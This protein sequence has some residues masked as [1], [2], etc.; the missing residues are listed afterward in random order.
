[1]KR[2]NFSS[3]NIAPTA[4]NVSLLTAIT[5]KRCVLG[6]TFG[7][8]NA[9]IWV[10]GCRGTFECNGQTVKC[11]HDINVHAKANLRKVRR[12]ACIA[13]LEP[14]QE[15][16]SPCVAAAAEQCKPE[17]RTAP[18]RWAW[19][20]CH[21]RTADEGALGLA[22]TVVVAVRYSE[23]L[24]TLC[25]LASLPLPRIYVVNK[26]APWGRH[27]ISKLGPGFVELSAPN[28]GRESFSYLHALLILR[29]Y[30]CG[31]SPAVETVIFTQAAPPKNK[32]WAAFRWASGVALNSI[33]RAMES[34]S[35]RGRG[36]GG[37]T[38]CFS[39]LG[40]RTAYSHA[41]HTSANGLLWDFVIA[42]LRSRLICSHE[43]WDEFTRRTTY[44][45]GATFATSA[46]LACALP[47][48]GVRA[49]QQ[50]IIESWQ[51]GK[52]R[53]LAS[54]RLA[55]PLPGGSGPA[56]YR[57][58]YAYERS[59]ERLFSG[60]NASGALALPPCG[61]VCGELGTG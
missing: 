34:A 32:I 8:R 3:R 14:R 29:P 19:G 43:T 53:L 41:A 31:A 48:E 54:G 23:P 18:S 26:G 59:W 58:E 6:E 47:D 17:E 9:T 33:G 44:A 39:F 16:L 13:D 46:A 52:T 5:R 11:G 36:A 38:P 57:L 49:M 27:N 20:A 51:L 37:A 61:C 4:C 2:S 30:L 50:E 7:C 24:D 22:P 15:Q 56:I 42:Q 12:C 35:R 21:R 25:W 55:S 28:I 45:V 10:K 1:M 40:E 60:C